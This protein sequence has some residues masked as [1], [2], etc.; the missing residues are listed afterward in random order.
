M[1]WKSVRLLT[2]G[3]S[4]GKPHLTF[5]HWFFLEQRESG[6]PLSRFPFN[7]LLGVLL[8]KGVTAL[9][10]DKALP[11]ATVK[12]NTLGRRLKKDW[13][14]N[15]YKYLIILPILIYLGISAFPLPFISAWAYS[16]ERCDCID[17]RQNSPCC[18]KE[19]SWPSVEKRL[20]E[21]QI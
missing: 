19:H 21:E 1:F 14:K 4:L 9:T 12:K 6:F 5:S 17:L 8:Q 20:A 15:K 2:T 3:S 10:Y 16:S 18:E 7:S 11:A 13:Q